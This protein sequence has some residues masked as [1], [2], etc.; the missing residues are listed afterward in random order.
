[1]TVMT[2]TPL[3]LGSTIGCS[4]SPGSSSAIRPAS[5]EKA[6]INAGEWCDATG[7]VK[8]M[9][10]TSECIPVW[11]SILCGL[12]TVALLCDSRG[13]AE[14]GADE[15][16]HIAGCVLAHEH[17]QMPVAGEHVQRMTPGRPAIEP[18]ERPLLALGQE[19]LVLR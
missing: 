13:L 7:R 14:L 9:P 6:A 11:V 16:K 10:S 5:A 3:P 2:T 18:R 19:A 8:G 17:V 15:R 4:S 12:F 1:M